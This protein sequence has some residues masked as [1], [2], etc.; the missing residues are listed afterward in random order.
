M[1]IP[2]ENILLGEGSADEV[3][4]EEWIQQYIIQLSIELG[5][6]FK[7]HEEKAKELFLKVDNNKSLNK[8]THGT[9]KKKGMYELKG[10]ELGPWILCG[11]FD[12]TRHPLEKKNCRRINKAISDL[13]EFI[14]DMELVNLDFKEGK[15]TWKKGDRHNSATRLD[16]ILIS[17]EMDDGFRYLKK[18]ILQRFT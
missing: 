13:S 9:I 12:T 6:D 10:L 16:R 2:I 4:T 15:Y 1:Q 7:G 17:N 3:P 11:D 14:E 8:G 5:V 18:Y